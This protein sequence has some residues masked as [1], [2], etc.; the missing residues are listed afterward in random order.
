MNVSTFLSPDIKTK[1]LRVINTDEIHIKQ[2]KSN[3]DFYITGKEAEPGEAVYFE[4]FNDTK[5]YVVF[6]VIDEKDDWVY[7]HIALLPNLSYSKLL[8]Y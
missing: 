8:Y 2:L 4:F 3:K 5:E 1:E 7:A 6:K